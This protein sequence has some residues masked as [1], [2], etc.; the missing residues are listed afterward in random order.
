V[1]R[2]SSPLIL[3]C[4]KWSA[5]ETDP[6]ESKQAEAPQA[7]SY[8]TSPA[9]I[10]IEPITRHDATL[11][12]FR[13][14]ALFTAYNSLISLSQV[15]LT[16]SDRASFSI[17]DAV[18]PLIMLAIYSGAALCM[19]LGAGRLSTFTLR[20]TYS[21]PASQDNSQSTSELTRDLLAAGIALT[22]IW[23]L[24]FDAIPLLIWNGIALVFQIR[25]A[26][27][28]AVSHT[29]WLQIVNA[30]VKAGIGFFLFARSRRLAY[31]WVGQRSE[32]QSS[33]VGPL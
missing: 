17:R 16:V 12:A 4:I 23:L 1:Q 28:D 6:S 18:G 27:A 33:E 21:V 15:I 13:I 10:G 8:A 20:G 19:W 31:R 25:D 9:V 11:I 29:T 24:I 14:I 32:T 26:G 22:G 3:F 7:V 5:V 2:R 30:V